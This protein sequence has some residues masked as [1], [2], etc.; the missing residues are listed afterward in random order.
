MSKLSIL[1]P[2]FNEDELVIKPLLDS[3]EIQQ[4]VDLKK[5]IEVF[6]GN[7][8]SDTK[9]SI[10]FLKKYSFPIQ[11]HYFEHARLAGTRKKLFDVSSGNYVIFCDADDK[12]ISTIALSIIFQQINEGFDA[13]ICDF[14]EEHIKDNGHVI[15][16]PK[17]NDSVFVH[18]KVY[19][20]QFLLDNKIEWHEELHEH[21]DSAFNVLARICAK[22][23]KQINIPLYLWH[24][25]PNSISRQNKKY[26]SVNTW[27]AMIDSYNALVND[28]KDRGY[29]AHARYYA[30]Y[31]LYATYYEMS[32]GIWKQEDT[33]TQRYKTLEHL[34]Q[35]YYRHELLIKRCDEKATR[36]MDEDNK[37]HAMRRGELTEMPPFEEWLNSIITLFKER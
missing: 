10:E 20:R 5:D 2:Q 28:L 6:I 16:K 33:A 22:N 15:Y 23:I 37:K 25:N 35:F 12:F 14:M 11:Y 24:D 26:H 7:D 8:G 17:Q 21:Q 4:N 32:H 9:L 1:I 29:G 19:R 18:G 31:C 3:I 27:C 34:A 30:K 13:L 36:K